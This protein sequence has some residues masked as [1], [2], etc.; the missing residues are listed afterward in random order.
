MDGTLTNLAVWNGIFGCVEWDSDL[1]RGMMCARLRYYP[2]D[3]LFQSLN[4]KVCTH[5]SSLADYILVHTFV[6]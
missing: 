1:F 4:Q 5:H 2:F 3:M 6:V